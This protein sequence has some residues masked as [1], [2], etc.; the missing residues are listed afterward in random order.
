MEQVAEGVNNLNITDSSNNIIINNINN[1]KNRI[2]VSNTKKPLFFYVNLA[3]VLI[4][5]VFFVEFLGIALLY[6][7]GIVCYILVLLP[8]IFMLH[9]KNVKPL[10]ILCFLFLLFLIKIFEF[11][12]VLLIFGIILSMG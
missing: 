8:I 3:K 5:S 7:L 1:K 6:L 10:L 9:V 11:S 4:F 12:F 2:Q